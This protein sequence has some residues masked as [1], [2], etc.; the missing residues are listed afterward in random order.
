[1]NPEHEDAYFATLP[2]A[3]AQFTGCEYFV[4]VLRGLF[5]CPHKNSVKSSGGSWT[6]RVETEG[7]GREGVVCSIVVYGVGMSV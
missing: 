7:G 6:V 3:T 5:F 4:Y 1:M 2:V